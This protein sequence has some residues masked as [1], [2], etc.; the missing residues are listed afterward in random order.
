M[1]YVHI[2]DTHIQRKS[3]WLL[4]T[5]SLLSSETLGTTQVVRVSAD[6]SSWS[7]TS[8]PQE[9]IPCLT[10][11]H[12]HTHTQHRH[13]THTGTLHTQTDRHTLHYTHRHTHTTHTDRH[14]LHYT[15]TDTTHTQ[16]HYTQT[17]R[18]T[19]T[20]LY[21][22]RHTNYTQRILLLLQ[23]LTLTNMVSPSPS[24]FTT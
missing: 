16:T 22:H 10:G 11:E 14:T 8:N 4:Y 19:H 9:A 3:L 6:K 5:W 17:D 15:H 12:T 21:T 2:T 7:R 20:T 18:Q 1:L 13:Y 23:S 24:L